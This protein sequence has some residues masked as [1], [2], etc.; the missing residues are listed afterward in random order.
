MSD[1]PTIRIR[2]G[3][4]PEVKSNTRQRVV[5]DTQA[6][7]EGFFRTIAATPLSPSPSSLPSAPTGPGA[8]FGNRN[9][10]VP[11]VV[12]QAFRNYLE[13]RSRKEGLDV[14]EQLGHKLFEM[15]LSGDVPAMKEFFDRLEGKSAQPLV[16]EAE[17]DPI[18]VNLQQ[19][20]NESR[21]T[22]L[23]Q[24]LVLAAQG[25]NGPNTPAALLGVSKRVNGK[26]EKK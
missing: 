10:A 4:T 16:G 12:R 23:L 21:A 17:A 11:R 1:L 18:D 5:I 2:N 9:N 3:S 13:R 19:L 15:G 25:G 20:S 7:E 8:P 14:L 6:L 24:I 22:R 26:K